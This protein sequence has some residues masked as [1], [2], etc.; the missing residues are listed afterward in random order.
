MGRPLAL[1]AVRRRY[2]ELVGEGVAPW[3]AA[4]RLGVSET[5]GGRWFRHAGGVKPQFSDPGD[6]KW[7][8]LSA[9]EREEISIGRARGSRCAQSRTDSGG[10]PQRSRVRS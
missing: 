10:R 5:T 2:W 8:R 9:A 7:Q 1:K 3:T 6:T 4:A